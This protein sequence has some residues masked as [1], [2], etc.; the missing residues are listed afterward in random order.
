MDSMNET[1]VAADIVEEVVTEEIPNVVSPK[2]TEKTEGKDWETQSD[3]VG[4]E[5]IQ[6][7][8]VLE[9]ERVMKTPE[10]SE[11]QLEAALPDWSNKKAEKVSKIPTPI[12]EGDSSEINFTPVLVSSAKI[13]EA[14][15]STGYGKSVVGK[16]PQKPIEQPT[17]T[18]NMNVGKNTEKRVKSAGSQYGKAIPKK[19]VIEAPKPSFTPT[20]VDSSP[21]TKSIRSKAISKI[22]DSQKKAAEKGKIARMEHEKR[23]KESATISRYTLA[24]DTSPAPEPQESLDNRP[25]MVLG[26]SS[27]SHLDHEYATKRLLN[28]TIVPP[29]VVRSKHGEKL[30]SKAV[31]H[32][33]GD[34]Y[35][36]PQG[37]KPQKKP[38]PMWK[39]D[40]K[41]TVLPS[42]ELSTPE[43]SVKHANAISNYGKS[44]APPKTTRPETPKDNKNINLNF[45]GGP[46]PLNVSA[47]DLPEVKKLRVSVSSSG[48]GVV[49]PTPSVPK[50]VES[51]K[52]RGATDMLRT[53][54]VRDATS[55]ANDATDTNESEKENPP[56]L[57]E[58]SS[59]LVEDLLNRAAMLDPKS[60]QS[61]EKK[62]TVLSEDNGAVEI[63]SPPEADED[64]QLTML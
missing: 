14:A 7:E 31:S 18:P 24:K 51:Y 19:K 55:L 39:I 52:H 29:D 45:S 9:T 12:K 37:V 33:S 42:S 11:S 49:S 53:K 26:G 34:T 63:A 44:Y 30:L 13:R 5:S 21:V 43:K 25:P 62:S 35:K 23:L 41:T 32:Y 48:Y 64:T 8:V 46:S 40:P 16:K 50:K 59:S 15:K 4:L 54:G 17:F 27:M 3:L 28:H 6:S 2:K 1:S 47:A 20:L 60:V 36:L 38:E 57:N 10:P 61:I 58:N 22:Y 56:T